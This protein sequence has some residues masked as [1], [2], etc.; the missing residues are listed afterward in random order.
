MIYMKKLDSIKIPADRQRTIFDPNAHQELV[1][2]IEEVGLINA[3]CVRKPNLKELEENI[4]CESDLILVAGERRLRAVTELHSLEVKFTFSEVHVPLN[5][6]PCTLYEDL[7]VA[8]AVQIEL[9]ENIKRSN[10]TWQE[11]A[12]ATQRLNVLLGKLSEEKSES[13]PTVAKL[14]ELIT[15]KTGG[16]SQ[17]IVRTDLIVANHLDNPAVS[18]ATSAKEALKILKKE[19]EAS[20]NRQLALKIGETYGKDNN[21]IFHGDCLEVLKG[22]E[23]TGYFDVILTDPPYGMGADEFGDSAGKLSNTHNY[24]DSYESWLKLMQIFARVA[25]YV[26]KPQAHAYIFCDFDNFH[27]L[28]DFMIDAGWDVFRTPLISRKLNSGRVPDPTCGPRRQA[29]FIL[30]AI[31]GRKPVKVIAPDVIDNKGDNPHNHAAGKSSELYLDLLRRS[32]SPGDNVLDAFAGTFT[33]LRAAKTLKINTVAIEKDI[34]SYGIGVTE[35][36]NLYGE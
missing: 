15:G 20:K 16:S 13:P 11:Q 1:T 10:I 2:S 30:Y 19:E 7:T 12:K 4:Y 27:V 26:T 8:E 29:E 28:K 32:V 23:F 25:Y 17:D 18:K 33:I 24:D 14:T 31:K 3:I 34:A 6:V 9:D 21:K 22:F 5:S 36:N 35:L